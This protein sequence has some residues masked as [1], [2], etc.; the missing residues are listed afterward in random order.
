MYI[1]AFHVCGVV[2]YDYENAHERHRRLLFY[3]LSAAPQR[4]HVPNV[5]VVISQ[6]MWLLRTF[7]EEDC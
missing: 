4:R 7:P 6:C 2:L 3:L 5:R 1:T